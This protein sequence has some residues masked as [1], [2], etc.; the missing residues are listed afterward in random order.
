MSEIYNYFYNYTQC[1]MSEIY[2]YFYN[3][4]QKWMSEIYNYFYKCTQKWHERSIIISTI[5]LRSDK[6]IIIISTITQKW[7][8][9]D[10]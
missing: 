1:D 5:T 2:N 10:L 4:T 6:E 9:R 8:V 7:H 3:Y